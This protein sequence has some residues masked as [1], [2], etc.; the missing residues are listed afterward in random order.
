MRISNPTSFAGDQPLATREYVVQN[1]ANNHTV[2]SG[3]LD[4]TKSML[5]GNISALENKIKG[6]LTRQ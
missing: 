4:D 5:T 3:M 6:W 2:L 1:I